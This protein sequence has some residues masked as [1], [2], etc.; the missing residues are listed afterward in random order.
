MRSPVLR[1]FFAV[2]LVATFVVVVP[3]ARAQALDAELSGR[4]FA[5]DGLTPRS[6]VTVHLV[7]GEGESV[8]SSVA[9]N[10]DGTFA[11]GDAPAGTY[12]LLVETADG[13]FL[14]PEPLQLQPGANRPLALSLSAAADQDTG[15]GSPNARPT[16]TWVKWLVIG[17]L[18]ASGLYL[19]HEV[20][21]GE[22]LSSDF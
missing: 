15:L 17:V 11:I 2:L 7:R 22:E 19:V 6:G 5:A 14:S 1:R 13:A 10:S 16:R 12:S 4:V 8:Y 21:K 3:A 9:T 18:T 20:T